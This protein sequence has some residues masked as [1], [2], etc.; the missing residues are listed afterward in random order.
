M[1]SRSINYVKFLFV[2]AVVIR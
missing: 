1:P 2:T